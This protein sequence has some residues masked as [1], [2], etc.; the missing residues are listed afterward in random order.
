MKLIR[1]N[2]KLIVLSFMMFFAVSTT[3][4]IAAAPDWMS[5]GGDAEEEVSEKSEKVFKLVIL[6]AAASGAI[7]FGWGLASINGIIGEE[8][9]GPRK[10]KIGILTMVGSGMAFAI[11]SFF[12]G[13]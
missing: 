1:K 8:D 13:L 12:S 11:V 5:S 7:G 3:Y 4:A 9:K 10:I 2:L 6:I